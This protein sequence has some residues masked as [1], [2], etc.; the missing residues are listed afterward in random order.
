[1]ASSGSAADLGAP[2]SM[3]DASQSVVADLLAHMIASARDMFDPRSGLTGTGTWYPISPV[4][5]I[6]DI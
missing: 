2:L 3:E 1:M 4:I 5:T 6:S